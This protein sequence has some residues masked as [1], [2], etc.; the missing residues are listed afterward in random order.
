MARWVTVMRADELPP[1]R[2]V[3]VRV[4]KR[5]VA[6]VRCGEGGAL[7]ALDNR[8][9]HGAGQ[10]GDGTIRGED[11][12]CPLHDFG[13]DVRTGIERDGRTERVAIYPARI[14]GGEVQVDAEAVAPLQED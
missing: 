4:N 13:F 11:I 6:L 8:C 12:I 5:D 9:P 1:D 2:P 7:H 10:L 14:A 3:T